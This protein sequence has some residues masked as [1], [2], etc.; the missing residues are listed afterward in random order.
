MQGIFSCKIHCRE[1]LIAMMNRFGSFG[2]LYQR[3]TAPPAPVLQ[4]MKLHFD[5]NAFVT[6]LNHG[7]LPCQR[8]RIKADAFKILIGAPGGTAVATGHSQATLDGQK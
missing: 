4:F 1:S 5:F 6:S 8:D 3:V 2:V 7:A